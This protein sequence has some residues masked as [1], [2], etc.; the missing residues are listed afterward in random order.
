MSSKVSLLL[1]STDRSV[2]FCSQGTYDIDCDI[3]DDRVINRRVYQN[4][5]PMLRSRCIFSDA[6]LT[7]ANMLFLYQRLDHLFTT[8]RHGF[9]LA[10]TQGTSSSLI[11]SEN[12]TSV[13]NESIPVRELYIREAAPLVDPCV[14]F[15]QVEKYIIQLRDK[16]Q[17]YPEKICESLSQ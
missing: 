1:G 2:V 5:A 9:I 10:L 6:K 16:V 3:T 13:V 12:N 7:L 8:R 4:L 15:S 14:R 11:C 17:T